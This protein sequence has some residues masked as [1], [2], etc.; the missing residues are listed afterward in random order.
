MGDEFIQDQ[1]NETLATARK[2]ALECE[3]VK[4]AF[5]VASRAADILLAHTKVEYVICRTAKR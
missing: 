2:I 5:Q 4:A 3:V 1:V